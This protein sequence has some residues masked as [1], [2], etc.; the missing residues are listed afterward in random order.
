MS[1]LS[2]SSWYKAEHGSDVIKF[3]GSI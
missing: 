3:W 2:S 1:L